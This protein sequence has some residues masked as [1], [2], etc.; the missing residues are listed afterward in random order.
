MRILN[1]I[2][3]F[4][5]LLLTC[6]TTALARLPRYAHVILIGADG[7]SATAIKNNPGRFKN[8]E[9]LIREGSWT[10][11]CRS[12]LPSSSAINWETL[13]S[14]AGSEMHGF[15]DWGSKVPDFPPVY[16]DHWGM[17]PTLFGVIRDQMPKAETGVIYSWD[18]IGYLYPKAAVS[19]DKLCSM[20]DE[21]VVKESMRYIQEKSPNFLFTYF[22]Q[23]DPSGHKYEWESNEYLIACDEVDRLVGELVDFIRK[24]LDMKST[25]IIFTS[26]HGGHNAV[27]GGKSMEDMNVLFTVVGNKIDKGRQLNFPMMKYDVAPT[28][29]QMLR[30]KAPEEWRGKSIFRKQE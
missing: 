21:A 19:Y 17:F 11:E 15:S 7:F 29:L 20:D 28:I 27:H 9:N 12:V 2:W 3:M 6:E 5:I 8:I 18:G 26:D 13:L 23:P 1:H 14:G 4:A 16:V 10:L 30:L 25:A 22:S 24:H